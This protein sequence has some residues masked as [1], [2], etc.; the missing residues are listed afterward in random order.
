MPVFCP[1][2]WKSY[3]TRGEIDN[4]TWG[5]IYPTR[6]EFDEPPKWFFTL[7]YFILFPHCSPHIRTFWVS[8]G[9][10][11]NICDN[12]CQGPENNHKGLL[13]SPGFSST[14]RRSH[15]CFW[16]WVWL[17]HEVEAGL[18]R[19]CSRRHKT[20]VCLCLII[21]TCL[22]RSGHGTSDVQ[23]PAPCYRWVGQPPPGG[24]PPASRRCPTTPPD[25]PGWRRAC[26]GSSD[27]RIHIR[28]C[29]AL[30]K[31]SRYSGGR[32]GTFLGSI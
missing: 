8:F 27:V 10:S 31:E 14:V 16:F 23:I 3:Y 12:D 20:W 11:F 15:N 32:D 5:E 9:D 24:V 13:I 2:F 18:V 26:S 30:L 6:S 25:R 28:F 4:F 29:E 7:W 21:F 19:R 22:H 1:K 17:S